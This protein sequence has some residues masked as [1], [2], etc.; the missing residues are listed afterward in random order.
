[1]FLEPYCKWELIDVEMEYLAVLAA[2][3]SLPLNI[4]E[5]IKST[6]WVTVCNVYILFS[7]YIMGHCYYAALHDHHQELL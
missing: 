4:K 2:R 3:A 5:V 1:M 6:S 7:N